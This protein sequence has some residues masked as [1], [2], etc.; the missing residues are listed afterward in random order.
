MDTL[1]IF[2]SLTGR[3]H[4]EAKHLAQDIG[5]DRYEVYERKYR[6]RLNVSLTGRS[7]ARKRVNIP[8]EPIAVDFN[9]FDRI[10]IMAPIWGGYPAPAFNSILNEIPKGK[11]IEIILTSDSGKMKDEEEL[12]KIVES[13][14]CV[15]T[16]L[17]VM[18]TIDLNKRDKL[19]YERVMKEKAE[20]EKRIA[21]LAS[22]ESDKN[23]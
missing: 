5:A 22:E 23:A 18:K 21:E 7:Q 3:T 15:L 20:E 11:Q 14:G 13:K 12:K 9:D 19:H 1:V 8:I 17:E 2:Y 16:K 10:I 4:Y 6:S